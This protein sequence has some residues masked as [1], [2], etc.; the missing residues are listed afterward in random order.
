LQTPKLHISGAG[1][2]F[3]WMH[4]MLNSVESDSIYSLVDFCKLSELVQL[5]RYDACDKAID[6]DYSWNGLVDE[7]RAII[8]S[9]SCEKAIL[10]G[11]SMGSGTALYTAIRYPELVKALVLVTPPPAWEVRVATQ[12]LY[13]KIALKARPDHLPDFLKRIIQRNQ[14]PPEFYEQLFPGTRK[15][16]LDLRTNFDPAY[17]YSI[18][19]GG[20]ISDFPVREKLKE[21]KI[22]TLIIG[23]PNDAGHP[24]DVAREMQSLIPDCQL[25]EL[26]NSED[27]LQLQEIVSYFVKSIISK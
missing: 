15:K 14:D 6:G 3:L 22:P 2:P 24:I 4:G 17:Y 23:D 13:E 19:H 25:I 26:K 5:I 7:L 10:G 21:V 16:L 20:A 18:Y 12:A 11:V 8:E 27:Y 9:L 1:H